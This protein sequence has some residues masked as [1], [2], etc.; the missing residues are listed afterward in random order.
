[1]AVSLAWVCL[2]NRAEAPVFFGRITIP[3]EYL[4]FGLVPA[5]VS[6]L[7][8]GIPLGPF[9]PPEDVIDGKK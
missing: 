6:G 1:M 2:V 3:A 8:R 7:E 4:E 5:A 9:S